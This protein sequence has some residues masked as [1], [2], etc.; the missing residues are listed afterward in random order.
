MLPQRGIPSRGLPSKSMKKALPAK[1]PTS[2]FGERKHWNK[3]QMRERIKKVS[4]FIVKGKMF[5]GKE[6]IGMVEQWF[7]HKRFGTHITER[8][9]KT[10]LRELRK[11]E[12]RA[13]IGKE[14]K[15]YKYQKKLL[16]AF[17]GVKKY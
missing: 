5:K 16:E 10:R 2:V 1:A 7:P 8:E 6:R 15:L 11:A 17:T 9:V 3:L 14:K 12:N 13:Q 4:P